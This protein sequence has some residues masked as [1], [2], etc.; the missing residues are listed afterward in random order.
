MNNLIL[1][2]TINAQWQLL[3]KDAE[4]NSNINLTE[5]LESYLVFLLVRFS[6]YGNIAK[7]IAAL[8]FLHSLNLTGRRQRDQLQELGDKCLLISGLFPGRAVHRCVRISYFVNLGQNAYVKLAELSHNSLSDFYKKLG[9]HFVQLMDVLH[10]MREMKDAAA[11]LTVLQAEELWSDLR[12][13]HAKAILQR[14]TNGWVISN[15][16][17]YKH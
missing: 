9:H 8:E 17:I 6:T 12:S 3:I 16:S 15:N 7:T 5:D 14:F 13:Q 2:P 11:G 4:Q 1:E 10:T